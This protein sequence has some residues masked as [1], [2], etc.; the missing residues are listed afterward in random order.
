[1]A[2]WFD[3]EGVCTEAYWTAVRARML[4]ARELLGQ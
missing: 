4:V 3:D 1:V 2:A